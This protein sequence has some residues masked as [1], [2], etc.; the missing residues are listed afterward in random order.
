MGAGADYD[1]DYDYDW[2]LSGDSHTKARRLQGGTGNL[3][4]RMVRMTRMEERR[5][6]G[7]WLHIFGGGR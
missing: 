7:F 1:Q 3:S 5:G 6:L 2:E 4:L